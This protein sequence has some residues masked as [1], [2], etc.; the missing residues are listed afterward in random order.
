MTETFHQDDG[1]AQNMHPS[2]KWIDKARK[3]SN[4]KLG[5]G[6]GFLVHSDVTICDGNV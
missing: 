3:V 4:K 1:V 6:L 5:G 2:Y